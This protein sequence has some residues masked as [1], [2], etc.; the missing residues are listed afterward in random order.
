MRSALT[1]IVILTSGAADSQ[2]AAGFPLLH[3]RT[4]I[5]WVVPFDKAVARAK[6]TR[7]LLLIKPIA[8]GTTKKGCW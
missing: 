7:R 3:D 4:G 5:H 1:A 8:F 6:E 2:D